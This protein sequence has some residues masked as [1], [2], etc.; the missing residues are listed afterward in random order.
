MRKI[1][2]YLEHSIP[3]SLSILV[4]LS[5]GLPNTLNDYSRFPYMNQ[6][7]CQ[8][9]NLGNAVRKVLPPKEKLH[10]DTVI[11]LVIKSWISSCPVYGF[12][13]QDELAS[14]VSM[15]LTAI[16]DT[17][18][19]YYALKESYTEQNNSSR[20]IVEEF[21]EPLSSGEITFPDGSL[22]GWCWLDLNTSK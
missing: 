15:S 17:I 9:T 7:I 5:Y 16:Q 19:I 21:A 3:V 14:R 13:K 18:F 12:E 11:V 6:Q 2:T 22:H 4:M 1:L 8:D 20:N 10:S